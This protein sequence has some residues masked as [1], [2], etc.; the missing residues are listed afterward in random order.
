MKSNIKLIA[1]FITLFF[2][3]GIDISAQYNKVYWV[4]GLNDNNRFNWYVYEQALVAVRNQGTS[5]QWSSNY[6]LRSASDNLNYYIGE[7]VSYNKKAIVFGHSAGG[8]VAR[9]AALMPGNKIRAVITAGTPNKGA[10]IVA[11]MRSGKI[12]NV[13]DKAIHKVKRSSIIGTNAIA[14]S[15]PGV[16]IPIVAAINK[17]E[18]DVFDIGEQF[19]K[20]VLYAIF[21]SFELPSVDD[22]NPSDKKNLFLQNLNA[23]PPTIPIINIYGNEDA[24][25][26]VRLIGSARNKTKIDNYHDTTDKTYDETQFSLYNGIVIGSA[27][28]EGLHYSAGTVMSGLGFLNP[29]F[30]AP[31]GL[32]FAAAASWTDT[33]RYIQYDIH[34]DWD[35]IIGATHIDR[36]ENWHRFLW[37]KWCDV[38]Y[39][40]VYENSDGLVPNKSS[41]MDKNQGPYTRNIEVRGVNH[42]EMCRHSKMRK[43]LDN[44]LNHNSHEKKFNPNF[45]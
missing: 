36:V 2:S 45:E 5:I 6:S 27:I 32:N 25:R 17:M 30:F 19:A 12:I 14:F 7:E 33:R 42:L 18:S 31:A 8:L 13:V 39:V 4:H 21:K 11:S 28:I 3:F 26:L 40:T 29:Y 22:M 23:V 9:N 15:I 41:I 16:S 37:W 38:K 44:I 1:S 43:T 34:N 35:S 20:N 24:N 10:G